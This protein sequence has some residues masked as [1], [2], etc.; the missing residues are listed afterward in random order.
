VQPA[1]VVRE[2]AERLAPSYA[3]AV[4][5]LRRRWLEEAQVG[6]AGPGCL[7]AACLGG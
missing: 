5:E 1:P 4:G 3:V 2:L 7:R 6:R